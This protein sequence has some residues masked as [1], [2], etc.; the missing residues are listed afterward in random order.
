MIVSLVAAMAKNRT[1]GNKN[2]LIWHLPEDL[3]FFKTTTK[4]KVMIMGRK[5]FESLPKVLPNRFHIVISRNPGTVVHE[6]VHYVSS[7]DESMAKA[8]ELVK[9]GWGDEVCVVGG[10]EIYKLFIPLANK[11]Y[12]TEINKAYEGDT[13]FPEFDKSLFREEMLKRSIDG[14]IGMDFKIYHREV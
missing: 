2:K 4:N 12:L 14:N 8:K 11:I 13:F 10:A 5:T 1:I 3:E 9:S 7:V 6:R